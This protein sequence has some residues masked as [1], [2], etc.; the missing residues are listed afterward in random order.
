MT[1]PN[2]EFR[3]PQTLGASD[4]ATN[5]R[6][7]C[8]IATEV[9]EVDA[10]GMQRE[11]TK[12]RGADAGLGIV[13]WR[14]WVEMPDYSS[15][16]IKAKI[17]TGARTSALHA[18]GLELIS[19]GD[20]VMARFE[21]LPN[22][23]RTDQSTIVEAPVLEERLVRSSNGVDELR[24]V[25]QTDLTLG[26]DTWKIEVT[27]SDRELMGFRMLIGRSALR[28]RFLVDPNRSFCSHLLSQVQGDTP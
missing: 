6:H 3:S 17:D 21:I 26:I 18:H 2:K 27:L 24:P 10:E 15:V 22:Q 1:L 14:E 13:G 16:Q 20:Q 28:N 25:I 7:I 8:V 9:R 4:G 12:R 19:D 23:G 11:R 5:K